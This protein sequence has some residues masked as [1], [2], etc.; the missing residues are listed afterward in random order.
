M[1][2]VCFIVMGFASHQTWAE[3]YK[4]AANHD[5]ELIIVPTDRWKWRMLASVAEYEHKISDDCEIL[6]IDGMFDITVLVALLKS[7]SHERCPRIFVYMHENQLTTPFTEKDRDKRNN[8][9]WHYGLAHLRSM[10]V[11]DGLIFNSQ[12]H[13]DVFG[14][15]LPKL[16]NSQCPRD[17]VAWHLQKARKLLETKC[18]I[19]RYGLDLSKSDLNFD[20]KLSTLNPTHIPILL[21]NARLEEDKNPESFLQLLHNLRKAKQL[22]QLIILG[23]D[24]SKDRK[25]Q[26]R[27]EK[28]FSEELL[29]L[30]WCSE[31]KEYIKWLEKAD[32]V[33]STANH[34]TFGISIVESVWYGALPFLPLRL[35]YPEIFP[36]DDF[37][38]HFY[39]SARES[40]PK[41]IKLFQTLGDPNRKKNSVLKARAAVEQ[42]QWSLMGPIYDN[43]FESLAIGEDIVVAGFVAGKAQK[44]NNKKN[45]VKINQASSCKRTFITK[46]ND[47][48]VALY[49]PK[50]LRDHREYHDQ[51]SM[52]KR[53]KL[54]PSLH[55]GRRAM[56][57]ML[58][59]ISIG[60]PV[61]P[62]SFLT[63]N[64]LADKILSVEQRTHCLQAPLYVAEKDLLDE[65]RGQKLNSGDAILAMIQ[66]PVASP[67][68][69]L[70]KKPPLLVLDDIRNAENVGSILR[71]AFCLG[72][73]SVVAS[74]TAWAALKDSRAA[75]CSMGTIYYH[76]FFKAECLENTILDLREKGVKVYGVEIGSDAKPVSP[77][78]KDRNW[79]MVVCNEDKGMTSEVRSV[80]DNIVFIP[81]AHG[82]SLNVGH[83]AAITMFQLGY[84]NP[85]PTHDGCAEC[86]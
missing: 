43:F 27:F 79:A 38:D 6:I 18:T 12:Q 5:V 4:R 63:T 15:A 3:G 33:I 46:A 10:M 70:V 81:Q 40:L 11:A 52:F 36:P 69:E 50:S 20:S 68:D 80:C 25:W 64:E 23:T 74:K 65:I 77:H 73:T 72:I 83:A 2:K 61:R 62:L 71:T 59:A 28:E 84:D 21:W 67:L 85:T 42:F 19:L 51:L 31:R 13:L 26:T 49:R 22:F 41:L 16:I 47:S 55:G 75:R 9:H 60:S 14:D 45:D 76:R 7:R 8:T 17:T 57:R 53:Q 32:I 34:E 29:H 48:Q 58:E 39:A 30:G 44:K 35:S 54:D 78:G 1:V 37:P 66:F 24:P 82:D 56:V 86:K